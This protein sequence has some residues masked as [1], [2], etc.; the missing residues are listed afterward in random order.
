MMDNLN[1][2]II[3]LLLMIMGIEAQIPAPPPA[4]AAAPVTKAEDLQY[5]YYTIVPTLTDQILPQDDED[6]QAIIDSGLNEAVIASILPYQ[7]KPRRFAINERV[8]AKNKD[9]VPWIRDNYRPQNRWNYGID[10][11]TLFTDLCYGLVK[12]EANVISGYLKNSLLDGFREQTVVAMVLTKDMQAMIAT[13]NNVF[14]NEFKD[15]RKSQCHP[16]ENMLR[17]WVEKSRDPIEKGELNQDEVTQAANALI[18]EQRAG[19]W[20]ENRDQIELVLMKKSIK[21][22]R[23]V[24]ELFE[25]ADGKPI[26]DTISENIKGHKDARKLEDAYVSLARYIKDKYKYIADIL[27]K[28]SDGADHWAIWVMCIAVVHPQEWPKVDQAFKQGGDDSLSKFIL[29]KL[30]E[31]NV[32]AETIALIVDASFKPTIFTAKPVQGNVGPTVGVPPPVPATTVAPAGPPPAPST[33]PPISPPETPT[34]PAPVPAAAP[35]PS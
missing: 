12:N 16:F 3:S 20:K 24:I 26:E 34:A 5:E 7:E 9:E 18:A 33:A 22:A 31:N 32:M 1:I 6:A 13:Y 14:C 30:T 25:Q 21:Y 17:V 8:S 27:R 35:P 28:F 19:G 4:P 15:D 29:A 11:Y 23:K 10:H 2:V